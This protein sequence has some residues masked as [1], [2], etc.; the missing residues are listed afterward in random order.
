MRESIRLSFCVWVNSIMIV[1][2]SSIHLPANFMMSFF[3]FYSCVILHC[4]RYHIIPVRMAKIKNT[5]QFSLAGE[6]VESRE[7]SSTAGGRAILY[8]HSG[9]LYGGFLENQE[10]IYLKTH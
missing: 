10:I 7:H 3:N 9:N 4:V 2:S 1:I 8:R 6:D 5:V